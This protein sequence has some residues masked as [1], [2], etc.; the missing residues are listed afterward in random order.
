MN[1]LTSSSVKDLGL[2]QLIQFKQSVAIIEKDRTDHFLVQA[3]FLVM[4][5]ALLS[6]AATVALPPRAGTEKF[7]EAGKGRLGA[8]SMVGI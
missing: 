3:L 2:W 5:K 6:L 7:R 4:L 1:C 8:V